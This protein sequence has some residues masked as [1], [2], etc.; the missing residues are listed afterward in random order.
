MGSVHMLVD[1][2]LS[3]STVVQGRWMVSQLKTP[4][5]DVRLPQHWL[6]TQRSLESRGKFSPQE[7]TPC[8]LHLS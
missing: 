5:S 1:P 4:R 8:E 7:G 2:F 6:G 3:G